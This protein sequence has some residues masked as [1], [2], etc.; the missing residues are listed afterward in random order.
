[1]KD[2]ERLKLLSK[3]V[4]IFGIAMAA[5]IATKVIFSKIDSHFDE[6]VTKI[7]ADVIGFVG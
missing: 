5:Q 4:A 7:Q 6:M 1:M 3:A 2:L